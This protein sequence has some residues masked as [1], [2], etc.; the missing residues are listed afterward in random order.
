MLGIYI[1]QSVHSVHA[2][3]THVKPASSVDQLPNF[4]VQFLS[5]NPHK[6]REI[7][8]LQAGQCGNQ[9]GAKVRRMFSSPYVGIYN[10]LIVHFKGS[11]IWKYMGNN[12]YG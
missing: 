9:I 5:K 8:H 3:S 10:C 7:V 1:A 12:L 11:E 6:M 4:L 2:T